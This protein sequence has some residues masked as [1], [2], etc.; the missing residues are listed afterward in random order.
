MAKINISNK[1]IL[2]AFFK[3]IIYVTSGHCDH[4]LRPPTQRVIVQ[5]D[6]VWWTPAIVLGSNRSCLLVWLHFAAGSTVYRYAS[7]SDG[8]LGNA[9]LGDF[10]V[11]GTP[12]S[13]L[14][15]T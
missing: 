10:V 4:S 13:V 12:Q 5:S 11:M 6:A 2:S 14:T 15:Q 3:F 1:N 8:D 9:P 7:L